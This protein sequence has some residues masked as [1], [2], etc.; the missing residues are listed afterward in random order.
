MKYSVLSME[1]SGGNVMRMQ[2][3]RIVTITKKLNIG[4]TS[5]YMATRRIGLNGSNIHNAFVALNLNMSFPL[6]TTVNVY[7][8]KTQFI[9]YV[10][11]FVYK[12]AIKV[13]HYLVYY[14]FLIKK[15][16]FYFSFKLIIVLFLKHFNFRNKWKQNA[17]YTVKDYLNL[18][19]ISLILY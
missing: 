18:N 15:N 13:T 6:L 16:V 7:Q 17:W 9:R 1:S 14:I 10:A 19:M 11:H 3:T 2:L 8:R 12:F 4:W 5:I